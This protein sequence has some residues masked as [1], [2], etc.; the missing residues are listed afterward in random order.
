MGR[1]PPARGSDSAAGVLPGAPLVK[2]RRA[3]LTQHPTP[4]H[5]ESLRE[6]W[7]QF[8]LGVLSALGLLVLG[9]REPVACAV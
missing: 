1:L 4:T 3:P 7:R 6:S 8:L 2:S 9:G 5:S